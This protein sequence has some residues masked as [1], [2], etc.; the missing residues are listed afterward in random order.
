MLL[1]TG[2][3]PLPGQ[4]SNTLKK[5]EKEAEKIGV[6]VD[7]RQVLSRYRYI[8]I[9]HIHHDTLQPYRILPKLWTDNAGVTAR[10]RWEGS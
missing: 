6:G 4:S 10:N 3:A 7:G 5:G 1:Q 9:L 2:R 8:P